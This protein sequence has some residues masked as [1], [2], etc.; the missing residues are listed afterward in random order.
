[1][2]NIKKLKYLKK[3]RVF[4][5]LRLC[6][7]GEGGDAYP[8]PVDGGTGR[9]LG[10]AG[11]GD[12][13]VDAALV[14]GRRSDGDGRRFAYHHLHQA[15]RAGRAVRVVGSARV[16]TLILHGNLIQR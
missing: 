10:L 15:R 2:D 14:D 11:H 3:I 9:S 13:V 4:H 6:R 16:A 8:S 12:V 1:M 7:G 5:S